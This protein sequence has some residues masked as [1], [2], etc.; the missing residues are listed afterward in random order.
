MK[1]S[2]KNAF[3]AC[4]GVIALV[5]TVVILS[6][7]NNTN[8]SG[9]A[10]PTPE[11]PATFKTNIKSF[12]PTYAT[13]SNLTGGTVAMFVDGETSPRNYKY[14]SG[15]ISPL[16]TGDGIYLSA[17]NPTLITALFP[18]ESLILSQSEVEVIVFNSQGNENVNKDIV[19]ATGDFLKGNTQSLNFKHLFSL[20]EIELI[21]GTTTDDITNYYPTYTGDGAVKFTFPLSDTYQTTNEKYKHFFANLTNNVHECVIANDIDGYIQL[22][23]GIEVFP[24]KIFLKNFFSNIIAG[25]KYK[26]QITVN[27]NAFSVG[28]VSVDAWQDGST[29]I[30]DVII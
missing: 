8:D 6:S 1:F 4:I 12:N 27:Q 29:A 21:K 9:L 3:Y 25:Y 14:A 28:N 15:V 7:C 5:G 23:K 16:T 19:F 10:S 2:T 18:L 13:T 22:N 17:S 24:E 20:I 26:L 11:P 30:T